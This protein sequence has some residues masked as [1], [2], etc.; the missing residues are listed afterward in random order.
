MELAEAGMAN[1]VHRPMN[2]STEANQMTD[3]YERETRGRAIA[4]MTMGLCVMMALPAAAGAGVAV[5]LGHF[6]TEAWVQLDHNESIDLTE[7]LTNRKSVV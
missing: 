2:S 7:E 5:D 1:I 3:T 6:E 4:K